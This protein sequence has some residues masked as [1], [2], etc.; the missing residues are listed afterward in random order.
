MKRK[1]VVAVLLAA[2]AVLPFAS[3]CL[4][5][6]GSSSD[7][8]SVGSAKA[9]D[10]FGMTPL[11]YAVMSGLADTVQA[12][13]DHGADVNARDDEGQTPLHLAAQQGRVDLVQMLLAHN[14]RT[15]VQDEDYMTPLGWATLGGYTD[16]MQMLLAKK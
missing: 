7:A 8:S 4:A 11:H 6:Q 16:V 1:G 15:D 12:L 14:A 2:A 3:V 5:Q 10:F 9:K 13:L